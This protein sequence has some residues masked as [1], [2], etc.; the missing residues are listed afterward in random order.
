[1]AEHERDLS[2]RARLEEAAERQRLGVRVQHVVVEHAE[3]R[4]E[5]TEL[6]LY[7]GGCEPDLGARPACACREAGLGDATLHLVG[8]L[9][10][11]R[12]E[13][14]A[15]R[16]TGVAGGGRSGEQFDGGFDSGLGG[17]FVSGFGG[18]T[19]H[20]TQGTAWGVGVRELAHSCTHTFVGS[21]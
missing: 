15:E 12:T 3:V 17:G 11:A 20:G 8:G 10:V 1:M 13:V 14:L 21:V 4:L 16:G 6:L 7:D 19:G 18:L 9:D 2:L 5:D